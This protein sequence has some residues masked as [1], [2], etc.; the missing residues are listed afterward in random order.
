MNQPSERRPGFA[1]RLR[2]RSWKR[3]DCYW[4][5]LKSGKERR[6]RNQQEME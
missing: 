4:Q 1:R 3:Q 5:K 6:G 2:K